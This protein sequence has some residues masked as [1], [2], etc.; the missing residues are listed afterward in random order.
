VVFEK[1]R[2]PSKTQY[3]YTESSRK[4]TMTRLR[5]T[6]STGRKKIK[7]DEAESFR[8]GV[9]DASW[10]QAFSGEAESG[11]DAQVLQIQESPKKPKRKG[12]QDATQ[13][14]KTSPKTKGNKSKERTEDE[15]ATEKAKKMMDV[16]S[17][18]VTEG[19]SM[20]ARIAKKKYAVAVVM[21]LDNMIP[22]LEAERKTVQ[23]IVATGSASA[24]GVK[25][26]LRVA[27][28]VVKDFAEV[29][30]EGLHFLKD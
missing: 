11:D 3:L 16:L 2:N 9:L 18:K 4:K 5:E 28:V 17:K 12:V 13:K 14:A 23:N 24:E 29:Y 6:R 27:A 26:Q 20:K 1:L 22:L 10:G 21:D 15:K 30:Y 19:M 8:E 7:A 25:E